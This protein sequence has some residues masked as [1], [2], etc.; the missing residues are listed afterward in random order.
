M[1]KK[2]TFK[3]G[4]PRINR[5]GRPRKGKTLTDVLEK[6]LKRRNR[7]NKDTGEKMSG[8]DALAKELIQLALDGKNFA[9]IKYIFD[10]IDGFPLQAIESEVQTIK[11]KKHD[12]SK[13]T[14]EE[15]K[16]FRK[17]ALKSEGKEEHN[18]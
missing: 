7:E 16:E 11:K 13:L 15:L 5:S 1:N 14:V 12:L 8:K 2:G 17:L 4:D 10:R 6:H 3:K 9:A 18:E